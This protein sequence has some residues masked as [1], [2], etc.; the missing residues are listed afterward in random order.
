MAGGVVG[1]K[2]GGDEKHERGG[3]ERQDVQETGIADE[4]VIE[5]VYTPV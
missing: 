2:Q 1:D 4:D 3:K 5:A